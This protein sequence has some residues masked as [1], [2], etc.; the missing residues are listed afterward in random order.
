MAKVF[1]F[2][3]DEVG[4]ILGVFKD[5]N[6]KYSWKRVSSA[7]A[8]VYGIDLLLHGGLVGG[9]ILLVYAVAVAI[10]A[11]VTKT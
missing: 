2:I 11:A 4:T 3:Y 7:V 9:G 5:A 1:K 8:L 6:K 10:V